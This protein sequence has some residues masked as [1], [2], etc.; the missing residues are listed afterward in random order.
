LK[1]FKEIF[2][3]SLQRK[4][5]GCKRL[6]DISEEK[7]FILLKTDRQIIRGVILSVL[8]CGLST[9]FESGHKNI[10]EVCQ[11]D[12]KLKGLMKNKDIGATVS[13]GPMENFK[14]IKNTL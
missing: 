4:C 13:I 8:T 6:I 3:E 12:Y 1:T 14:K 9:L 7:Y 10:C 5:C 2:I 11:R